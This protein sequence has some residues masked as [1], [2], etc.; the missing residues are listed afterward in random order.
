MSL[1]AFS[2]YYEEKKEAENIANEVIQRFQKHFN[3]T[4]SKE[5]GYAYYTLQFVNY[6][7]ANYEK[8]LAVGLKGVSCFEKG[9]NEYFNIMEYVLNSYEALGNIAMLEQATEELETLLKNNPTSPNWS[10]VYRSK[11]LLDYIQYN[12]EGAEIWGQ[13]LIIENEKYKKYS[14]HEFAPTYGMLAQIY[15]GLAQYEEGINYMNKAIENTNYTKKDPELAAFYVNLAYIYDEK[16]DFSSAVKYYQESINILLN[17]K[18]NNTS[19]LGHVYFYLAETYFYEGDYQKAMQTLEQKNEIN[20]EITARD[21]F[22]VAMISHKQGKLEESSQL[23]QSALIKICNNFQDLDI[24]INPSLHQLYD[25]YKILA[26]K[27]LIEKSK[28]LY[29]L[30]KYKN[31]LQLLNASIQTS[32]F[33]IK[34]EYQNLIEAN[35]FQESKYIINEYILN[36][37]NNITQC[38]STIYS[39]TNSKNDF[40][41]LFKTIEQRKAIQL[42]ET[43]TPS[44]LPEAVYE[45]EKQLIK[46]LQLADQ[47]LDLATYQGEKDSIDF[48]QE[49][50][51]QANQNL[52]NF[53]K[54]IKREY[55]KETAE[56]Y[57]TD[58]ATVQDIQA[59]LPPQT[60][61]VSYSIVNDELMISTVG[62][63]TKNI[64]AIPLTEDLSDKINRLN[65]LIQS[66][67]AFQTKKREEFIDISN[68][69]YQIL[70]KPIQA[71]ITDKTTLMIVP[72]QE[73][74]NL[75][76]EVLLATNDKKAYSELDFFIKNI[77][78]IIIIPQ[79]L[80]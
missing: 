19:T 41:N 33:V 45:A 28:I 22:L 44:Y 80:S 1:Y 31:D 24:L 11:M 21:D 73:L 4:E 54:K 61:F 64:Y 2:I 57:E 10:V 25:E 36:N 48:Y 16:G 76:F 13:K 56:I 77:V 5:L 52:D 37:F 8:A 47:D 74:F 3:Q 7:I 49:Q 53:I 58:Y 46:N 42:I 6:S 32:Q 51:F 68:E 40:N 69:L 72:E 59:V 55:P 23:L 39:I 35:G 30:G 71:E 29:Q 12:Y 9:T 60:L 27:I 79:R 75:P 18:N 67:F 26:T 14:P 78:S 15:L 38:Y 66:D 43:L 20:K 17:D 63:S 70:I 50:R 34:I 65:Q 62:Q